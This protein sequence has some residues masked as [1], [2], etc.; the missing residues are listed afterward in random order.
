MARSQDPILGAAQALGLTTFRLSEY[1]ATAL[2]PELPIASYVPEPSR[3]MEVLATAL[4]PVWE[5]AAAS[6]GPDLAAALFAEGLGAMVRAFI[7][8]RWRNG[9]VDEA[10]EAMQPGQWD[11]VTPVVAASRDVHGTFIWRPVK[12]RAEHERLVELRLELARSAGPWWALEGLAI[13]ADRPLLL[14][15]DDRGRPHAAD[16]PAIAWP[17]GAEA[18]AWHGVAVR[19]EVI[20]A[21]ETITVAQIDAEVNVEVRRSLIERFGIERFMRVGGARLADEDETGRLWRREFSGPRNWR[22]RRDEPIVMVEVQ[23]STPEPD[24]SR[25]TYFLR[26]PPQMRTAREA[27][28]WTFGLGAAEYAPQT[29]T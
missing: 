24:G 8:E 27:V 17:D 18:F 13:I 4:G 12:E 25:R 22:W 2:R 5:Q 26:V 1:L 10:I 16:G 29:E 28:A 21:P 6:I 20:T 7:G 23:N 14:R 11:A 3:P 19:R 15:R 9:R